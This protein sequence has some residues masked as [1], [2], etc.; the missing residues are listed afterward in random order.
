M[1]TWKHLF[2]WLYFKPDIKLEIE[3]YGNL[4]RITYD[5]ISY[6]PISKKMAKELFAMGV[7]IKEQV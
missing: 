1:N 3:K 4:Y 6:Y 2:R 5:K 7:V